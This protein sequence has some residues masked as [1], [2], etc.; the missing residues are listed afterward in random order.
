MIDILTL[1][2]SRLRLLVAIAACRR[3]SGRS[4]TD[5]ELRLAGIPTLG[6]AALTALLAHGLC[7]R[8][9]RDGLPVRRSVRPTAEAW[10]QLDALSPLPAVEAAQ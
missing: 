4:P 1:P 2:D 8:D 6:S 10:E 9:W 3:V 7:R 5:R